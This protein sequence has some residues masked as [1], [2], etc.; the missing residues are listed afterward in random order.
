MPVLTVYN[1]GTG[2]S[3][4]KSY[5]KLEIVNCFGNLHAAADPGGRFVNWLITEGVGSKLDPVNRGLLQFDQN[6][7]SMVQRDSGTT[8][9]KGLL[10]SALGSG[11]QQ[12]VQNLLEVLKYLKAT[13]RTPTAINMIGWSRGAVTCIRQASEIWRDGT[14]G[15][16]SVPINIFAVDPVAGASA[17][18]EKQGSILYPNVRNFVG[19]LATGERRR[20]FYPK[21]QGTLSVASGTSTKTAWVH[22]P[23]I[24]SDV[25]KISGEPGIVV[26]DM[27]ARFLQFCGTNV[28]AHSG[29]KSSPTRLL[30]CYFNM[31]LGAKRIGT[32][33]IKGDK[34]SHKVGWKDKSSGAGDWMK[35]GGGFKDRKLNVEQVSGVDV[36][37]NVHHEA[38]FERHYPELYDLCFDSR[39]EPMQ[40][41][42]AFQ[43]PRIQL[44]LRDLE[45]YSP[46]VS[47]LLGRSNQSVAKADEQSWRGALD[48][49]A[50]V[51]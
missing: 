38:L 13:G 28:D 35:S 20:A 33:T 24:H 45:L 19:I 34:A 21:N 5:E 40:W 15:M 17:D 18:K 47:E 41:M 27:C 22:F 10:H 29:F 39:L 6:S 36:L 25:A 32:T 30:Q 49:C 46:G 12:N 50:L 11:V 43:A 3:S 48:A 14:L 16:A 26:F 37:V 51:P 2:G 9:G 42:M 44:R 1:H 31:V 8:F 7:G 4:T 23:G